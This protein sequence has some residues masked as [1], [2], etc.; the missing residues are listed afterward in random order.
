MTVA[1]TGRGWDAIDLTGPDGMSGASAV[2][3]TDALSAPRPNVREE[4]VWF[5]LNL[6]GVSSRFPS[7]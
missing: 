4:T 1:R 6:T 7:R 2:L 3:L 5:V